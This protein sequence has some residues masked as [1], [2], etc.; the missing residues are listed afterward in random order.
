GYLFFLLLIAA[1]ALPEVDYL[2]LMPLLGAVLCYLPAD[3]K[4]RAMMGDAG[5]NV[6]GLALGMYAAAWLSLPVR[7]GFL[8]FLI[9]MHLYTEKYS[10]T[11]T[12]ENNKILR[13]IDQIGRGEA[14]G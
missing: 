8:L 9:A 1:F 7:I 12:I 14:N 13:A 5:S 10:L 6:L 4:A 2:L 11:T 3:V